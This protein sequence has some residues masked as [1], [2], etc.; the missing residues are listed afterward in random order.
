[1]RPGK[2]FC[3]I[4]IFAFPARARQPNYF[5]VWLLWLG[6]E[7]LYKTDKPQIPPRTLTAS[8]IRKL[9]KSEREKVLA[10]QFKLGGR[11]YSEHPESIIQAS[12]HVHD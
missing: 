5:R 9:P 6:M 4:K 7:R 1:L 10:A 3:R 11:L 8:E 2:W 12:H